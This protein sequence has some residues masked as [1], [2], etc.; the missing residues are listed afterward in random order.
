M[1]NKCLGRSVIPGPDGIY[2]RT[3]TTVAFGQ[4]AVSERETKGQNWEKSRRMGMKAMHLS[5]SMVLSAVKAL[6]LQR[7]AARL[8][9]KG[10]KEWRSTGFYSTI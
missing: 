2:R 6:G 5:S 3:I 9:L 8:F 10:E 4:R 7:L 1:K